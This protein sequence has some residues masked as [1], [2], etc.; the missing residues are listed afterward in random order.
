[1]ITGSIWAYVN[2]FE[3]AEADAPPCGRP[4]ERASGRL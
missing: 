4:G 3:V 2:T 1:L